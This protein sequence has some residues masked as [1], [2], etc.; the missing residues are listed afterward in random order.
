MKNEIR[1]PKWFKKGNKVEITNN[2]ETEHPFA[3]GEIVTLGDSDFYAVSCRKTVEKFSTYR[4]LIHF[5]E[6][7]PIQQ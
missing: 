5:S 1:I 3:P 6:C 2:N 7:K 4:P